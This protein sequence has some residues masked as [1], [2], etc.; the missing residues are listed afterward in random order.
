MWSRCFKTKC[1]FHHW[2]SVVGLVWSPETQ[3]V[4]LTN[5]TWTPRSGGHL[6]PGWWGCW[7]NPQCPCKAG[8]RKL[9]KKGQ[10]AA[11]NN[12]MIHLRL[13]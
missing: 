5:V 10:A 13:P 3:L 1:W 9:P 2:Q 4:K 8:G 12:V 7:D 6:P 11:Q